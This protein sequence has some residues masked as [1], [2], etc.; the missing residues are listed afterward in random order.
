[1]LTCAWV[2]I[3]KT[4]TVDIY[5]TYFLYDRVNVILK[6]DESDNAE[7]IDLKRI[8][9][10]S[11]SIFLIISLTG[12]DSSMEIVGMEIEKYPNRIVYYTGI[13]KDLDLSGGVINYILKGNKKKAA[14]MNDKY[15]TAS[16][17]IDF[18]KSGVYIVELNRNNNICKFPIEVIDK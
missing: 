13:D 18:N 14:D 12:C 9:M 16:Y 11:L 15:I 3:T 1:M 4:F 10:L 5:K 6:T 7:V 17:N 2:I 8:L